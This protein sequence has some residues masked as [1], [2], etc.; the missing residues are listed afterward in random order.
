MLAIDRAQH[1]VALDQAREGLLQ[2][3]AF[4]CATTAERDRFVV[5]RVRL[6]QALQG[7]EL[8]LLRGRRRDLARIRDA[9]RVEQCDQLGLACAQPGPF[10]R[11]EIRLSTGDRQTRR[12]A[13]KHHAA[14]GEREQ[15]G[16]DVHSSRISSGK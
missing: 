2:S 1:L 14:I 16:Q 5:A 15:Q 11:I 8:A 3:Q 7:P 6:I 4:Q 10:G 12:A 13:A 9:E